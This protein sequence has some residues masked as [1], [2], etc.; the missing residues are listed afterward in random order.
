MVTSPLFA[1]RCTRLGLGL[2]WSLHVRFL[3]ASAFFFAMAG[4]TAAQSENLGD[5]AEKLLS[6]VRE[7]HYQHRT[8]VDRSRGAYD[9]DCS[10]F[11]DYLLEQIAPA[12]LAPLRIEPGH[13]R[14]RAAMYFDLFTRLNKSPLPGWEAVP[15][16][17][18]ARRG[19]II[20]WQ[21]T[22][23]TDGLEIPDMWSSSQPRRS[24]KRLTFT[25]SKSMTRAS[26]ITTRTV[27]RKE[28]A[29]SEKGSL[30]SESMRAVNQL[31]FSS[32]RRRITTKS[33]SPSAVS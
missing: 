16:L 22:A 30:H 29:E 27:D 14:P 31:A 20:A 13:K 4:A 32:T 8:H 2:G 25:V 5:A 7:T 26:F 12:Q 19:D 10:G 23:S 33:R 15:K 3:I 18:K 17:G 11:V 21:L 1:R 28:R 24:S 6:G 9:M